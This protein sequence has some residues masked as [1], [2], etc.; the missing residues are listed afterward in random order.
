MTYFIFIAIVIIVIASGYFLPL[1][2][3][4]E[5]PQQEKTEYITKH[6]TISAEVNLT[7]SCDSGVCKCEEKLN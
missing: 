1:A 4:I 7:L 5:M 3:F 2:L 6:Y